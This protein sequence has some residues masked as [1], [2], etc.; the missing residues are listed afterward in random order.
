M[1]A[2]VVIEPGKLEVMEVPEVQPNEYQALVRILFCSI[3]NATDR[4]LLD[5]VFPSVNKYPGILGHESVGEVVRVGKKVKR[6]RVGD[7]VLRP[8]A[9]YEKYSK[10]ESF[11][12]GFAEY[13]LVTDLFA[14]KE[15]RCKSIPS[16]FPQIQQIVPREIDPIHATIIIT[17]KETLGWLQKFQVKSGESILIWGAGPVGLSFTRF[18][19]LL[20]AR[21]V[22][23]CARRE[24][25]LALATKMG[26]DETINVCQEDVQK[27]VKNITH[28]HGVQKIIEAVGNY[29]II[30]DSIPL[31][32]EEGKIGL[33]GVPPKSTK[34]RDSFIDLGKRENPWWSLE[35]IHTN[36]SSA[37]N[38]VIDAVKLGFIDPEMFVSEVLPLEKIHQAFQLLDQKK[39]VKVVIKLN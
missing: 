21:P 24:E 9:F 17:F 26:A 13:G 25:A 36:E 12:G 29:Q 6:Y 22:I 38:Q 33:Y 10:V 18:A 35:S 14:M 30:R 11:W 3:C 37:H 31:L 23:V 39:A 7:I 20:G 32:A 5:G 34:K 16:V 4:H 8:R 15:N 28:G 19:K 1:K 2:A 27:K